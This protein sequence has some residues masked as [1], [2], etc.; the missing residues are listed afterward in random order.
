MKVYWGS[1]G[2]APRIL[3]L[4]TGWRCLISFTVTHWIRGWVRP[5]AD[6]DAVVK[7]KIPKFLPGLGS[8]ETI[9]FNNIQVEK[10]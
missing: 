2:I 6:L 10:K 5:I 9:R 7:R 4:G 3:D 8:R 1:E